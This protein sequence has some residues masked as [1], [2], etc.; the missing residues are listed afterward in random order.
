MIKTTTFVA[1]LAFGVASA[2]T[3]ELADGTILETVLTAPLSVPRM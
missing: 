2:D 1:A 3:L